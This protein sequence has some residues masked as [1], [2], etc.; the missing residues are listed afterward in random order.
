M[1]GITK[2]FGDA[3][4]LV[5]KAFDCTQPSKPKRKDIQANNES[6]KSKTLIHNVLVTK[7]ERSIYLGVNVVSRLFRPLI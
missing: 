7:S 1:T 4:L 3:E 6:D 5:I 2:D